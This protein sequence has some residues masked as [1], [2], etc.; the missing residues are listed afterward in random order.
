MLE[1]TEALDPTLA[2]FEA[3]EHAASFVG[4]RVVRLADGADRYLLDALR[5]RALPPSVLHL[6][7]QRTDPDAQLVA[8]ESAATAAADLTQLA[9]SPHRQVRRRL[10]QHPSLP[11]PVVFVL[12]E[13][14]SED[15]ATSMQTHPVYVQAQ[16]ARRRRRLMIGG[17][18]GAATSGSV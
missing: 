5:S 3:L 11:E 10:A 7:A 13:D 9:A 1:S 6:L 15:I 2:P 17:A 16:Q 14:E 12:A 4:W 8:A 18:V